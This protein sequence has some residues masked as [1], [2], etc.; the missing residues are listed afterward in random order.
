[1][2]TTEDGREGAGGRGASGDR[3]PSGSSRPSTSSGGVV[4][5]GTGTQEPADRT[6]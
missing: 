1:M 5:P 4:R 6:R 2:K 3:A